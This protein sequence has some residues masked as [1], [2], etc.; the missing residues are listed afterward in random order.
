MEDRSAFLPVSREDMEARGVAQ[1]DFV[2]VSG[3]AYVDH[4]S[5]GTALI[6]RLLERWGYTVC[7]LCQPDW[8]DAAPFGTFGPPR[9]AFLVTAGNL[10]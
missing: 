1:P 4:P 10:D 6:G 7:L 2:L 9:L 8:R 3:D 5:F